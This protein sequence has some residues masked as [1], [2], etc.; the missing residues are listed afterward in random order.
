MNEE[1]KKRKKREIERKSLRESRENTKPDSLF[2]NS[3]YY[4]AIISTTPILNACRVEISSIN[5]RRCIR[6]IRFFAPLTHQL[7]FEE[8]KDNLS[9]IS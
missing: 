3:E 6:D 7:E 1:K 9:L 5:C 8:R 4:L 2:M